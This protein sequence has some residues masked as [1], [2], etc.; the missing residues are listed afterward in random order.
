LAAYTPHA[1]GSVRTRGDVV[2]AIDMLKVLEQQSAAW[3][4]WCATTKITY[5]YASR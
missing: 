3:H 2:E 4:S 5:Y 1:N